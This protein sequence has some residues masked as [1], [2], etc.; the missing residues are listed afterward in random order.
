MALTKASYSMITGAPVNVLDYGVIADGTTNNTVALAAALAAV[1][2]NG[3][4]YFPAGVYCGY[5]LLRRNNITIMGDG[6]ASTTLKLPNNCPTITV[7]FE[8]GGTITGLPNVIEVGECALGNSANTYS[9]INIVGL[10]IDGNYTNNTAPTTDLFGHGIILTKSSYC[11]IDDVV[12]QNCFATGIDNVIN[13]N[14][15]KISATCI[16]CGNATI[17]GGHYP[18]F[19]INSSKYGL[20]NIISTGGYYGGRMLDNCYGN[21]FNITVYNPSI[22]GLVYN[23]QSGNTSYSN[24]INVTVV[25]GCTYGQGVNV[26]TNCTDSIVNATIRGVTGIGFYVAGSSE[27]LAPR[28]NKFKVN[29]FNCGSSSTY[30]AGLYNQYEIAS[31]YDGTTGSPGSVFAVDINGKYNQF[32]ISIE[33]QSTPQVRG[34]VIRLGAQYN[35][36]TDYLSNTTVQN[37]L[38]S[39]TSNTNVWNYSQT[40]LLLNSLT[41]GNAGVTI[42]SGSGSPEGVVTA[43]VGSLFLRNDGS[44]STTL[45]VKTS[46]TGN[47]GWTAK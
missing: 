45:Y 17:S 21:Q 12:A 16:S 37:F 14:Y 2:A 6:S 42:S 5:L 10:T 39:D 31:R 18:N 30:D 15:N 32:Y 11:F 44:T 7:P 4:L 38:N 47:T 22:T 20:F 28:G 29:T 19:D 27:S 26:G 46:G 33:D 43:V 40:L 24:T 36:I 25:N 35:R 3:T 13:S 9:K 1:P 41:I 34:V 8:G 23:N